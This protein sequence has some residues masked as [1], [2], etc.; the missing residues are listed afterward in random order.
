ME[1][2]VVKLVGAL[3]IL[4]VQKVTERHFGLHHTD[5]VSYQL[6]YVI[7]IALLVDRA[8]VNLAR[9]NRILVTKVHVIFCLSVLSRFDCLSFCWHR[10]MEVLGTLDGL[11]M[12]FVAARRL[13][14][15]KLSVKGIF[16]VSLI[17]DAILLALLTL[18]S[19][20]GIGTLVGV[21]N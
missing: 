11:R 13:F 8:R 18:M 3:L 1:P 7:H 16:Y 14:G 21:H 20:Y 4:M 6:V 15:S 19:L 5:C 12:A 10:S 17:Y 9:C 2:W